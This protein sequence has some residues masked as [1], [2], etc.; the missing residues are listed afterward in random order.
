M[1]RL[2]VRAVGMMAC[3]F[4]R[5]RILSEVW[6]TLQVMLGY[7]PRVTF[8]DTVLSDPFPSSLQTGKNWALSDFFNIRSV[9]WSLLITTTT[10]NYHLKVIFIK[11]II[12]DY[13]LSNNKKILKEEN[14][15]LNS[16][17]IWSLPWS[18]CK[19]DGAGI[20]F[21]LKSKSSMGKLHIQRS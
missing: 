20:F 10:K 6:L 1:R 7:L 3:V 19:V 12:E 5:A 15:T 4:G 18:P 16:I 9:P 14:Q 11:K 17:S 13:F 8:G 21:I 2:M